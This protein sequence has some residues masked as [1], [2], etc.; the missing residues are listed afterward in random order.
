MSPG[1]VAGKAREGFLETELC[2]WLLLLLATGVGLP[3][4]Y[5]GG[6]LPGTGKG[7]KEKGTLQQGEQPPWCPPSQSLGSLNFKA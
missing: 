6:V 3:G 2:S 1:A 4:V 5:P 7:K